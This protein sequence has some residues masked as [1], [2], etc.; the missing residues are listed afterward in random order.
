MT[1]DEIRSWL[2]LR[3]DGS[4]G[5]LENSTRYL[6][7]ATELSAEEIQHIRGYDRAVQEEI[8]FLERLLSAMEEKEVA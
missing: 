5:L 3:R 1:V 8:W 6:A 7:A 2:Q 4:Q